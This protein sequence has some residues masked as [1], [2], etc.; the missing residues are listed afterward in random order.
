MPSLA[1]AL[2]A[3]TTMLIGLIPQCDYLENEVVDRVTVRA[4][5][6]DTLQPEK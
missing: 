2:A 5:D 1:S 4:M 3:R 6:L